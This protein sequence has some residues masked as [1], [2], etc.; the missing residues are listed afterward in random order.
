MRDHKNNVTFT[1]VQT[2]FKIVWENLCPFTSNQF[3]GA[4]YVFKRQKL[5]SEFKYATF[6]LKIHHR[7]HK[8]P[9]LHFIPSV[10]ISAISDSL[11]LKDSI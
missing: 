1:V 3:R 8:Y 11:F 2:N 4:A 9:E 6:Y 5:L 7:D 10:Y